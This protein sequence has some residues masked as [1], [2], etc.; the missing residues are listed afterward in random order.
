MLWL[1]IICQLANQIHSPGESKFHKPSL[2]SIP[3]LIKLHSINEHFLTV[4][5]FFL[6]YTLFFYQELFLRLP[7]LLLLKNTTSGGIS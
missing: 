6:R 4:F 1:R 7:K 3:Q 2:T 5:I